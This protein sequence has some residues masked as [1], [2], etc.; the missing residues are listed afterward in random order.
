MKK[1]SPYRAPHVRDWMLH[2]GRSPWNPL[3]LTDEEMQDLW[4]YYPNM[5]AP[6]SPVPDYDA[7]RDT[8]F[9]LVHPRHAEVVN[10]VTHSCINLCILPDWILNDDTALQVPQLK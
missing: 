5:S 9:P 4:I 3:P 10:G 7:V 1:L 8:F 2:G 6:M